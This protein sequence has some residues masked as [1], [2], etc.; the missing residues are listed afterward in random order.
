M[1]N[2]ALAQ[3]I[4]AEEKRKA[5]LIEQ[6]GLPS[7]PRFTNED[8]EVAT[9]PP[10]VP[11][12]L[13]ELSDDDLMKLFVGLTRWTDYFGGLLAI[14]DVEERSANL[15]MEKAKALALLK[16]GG[17]G[18]RDDKVTY[19]KAAVAVDEEVT[20]FEAEYETAHAR[21][22]FAAVHFD[23]SERDAA[24]VSRE[25]TRRIGRQETNDRRVARWTP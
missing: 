23:A 19:A 10:K 21:R 16:A 2:I 8:G 14:E 17:G 11:L 25:L 22:R 4:A 24:L 1:K 18:G 3:V 6:I 5:Q 12:T 7:K 15:I 20:K 9:V 13:S